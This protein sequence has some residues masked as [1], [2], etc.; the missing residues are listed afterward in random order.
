MSTLLCCHVAPPLL[1]CRPLREISPLP[2]HVGRPS[3]PNR[4]ISPATRNDRGGLMAHP[5]P[6]TSS[7]NLGA[8]IKGHGAFCQSVPAPSGIDPSHGH[9]LPVS[10][11]RRE[12]LQWVTPCIHHEQARISDGGDSLLKARRK[13]LHCR[14]AAHSLINRGDGRCLAWQWV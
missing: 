9:S 2:P 6:F 4:E 12:I 14:K 1:S 11:L 10:P 7:I 5:L 3:N 8:L 13:I